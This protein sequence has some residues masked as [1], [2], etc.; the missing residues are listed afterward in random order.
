MNSSPC[1]GRSLAITTHAS[2]ASPVSP[3]SPV[4]PTL[5]LRGTS[6]RVFL[7]NRRIPGV[8]RLR[9]GRTEGP[10]IDSPAVTRL[11]RYFLP[12]VKEPPADAE[13][14]SHQLIVRAGLARQVAAGL[15]TFLPAGWRAHRRV[16][17]IIREEL[18]A[19][20][21]GEMLMPVLQPAEPWR[22]TGRYDI[23][24]IFKLKD[25]RGADL[26]LAMTHEEILT[27]H[28][29]REVRSYRD[30]PKLLYHFQTKERDEPRPR[31]P[32]RLLPAAYRGLRPHLRPQRARV[33]PGR[34]R[35]GDDGR[36]RR[37][38]VHGALRGGRERG[39]AVRLGLCRERRDRE[40]GAAGGRGP[41]RAVARAEGRRHPGR[42]DDRGGLRAARSAT[43]R[44]DQGVSH[45]HR[46]PR[47]P[48][49]RHPGRPPP[50]RDQA[51]ERARRALPAGGVRRSA[52]GVRRG[53][54]LHRPGRRAGPDARGRGAGRAVRP[55]RGR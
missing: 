32:G 16:E 13:A 36:L 8:N 43:G 4:S 39:G 19:I 17:Q 7:P 26:V 49:R 40:R 23:D 30:L 37:A 2:S 41:A 6:K 46:R 51:P 21:S 11:S 50:Q 47:A 27:W 53:A 34:G 22:K 24:E 12:T 31:G 55:R 42:D 52:Q 14:V 20:G 28:I 33:V 45:V 1:V 10:R 29:A 5:S 9:E 48:A 25:R 18:D 54:R 15:W 44:A 35:R 3:P 38:R